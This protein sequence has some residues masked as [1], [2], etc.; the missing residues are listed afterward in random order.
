VA[1]LDQCIL[2]GILAILALSNVHAV[3]GLLTVLV[4]GN[5]HTISRVLAVLNLC[6]SAP[7]IVVL[8]DKVIVASCK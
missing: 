1:L 2:L 4:F 6:I 5:V 8:R 3:F 7:L